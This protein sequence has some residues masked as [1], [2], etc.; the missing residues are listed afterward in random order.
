MEDILALPSEI[1]FSISQFLH[2]K[3]KRSY[4]LTCKAIHSSVF[5]YKCDKRVTIGDYHISYTQIEAIEKLEKCGD[6][7]IVLDAPPSIGKTLISLLFLQKKEG[8]HMIIV[9]PSLI[10]SWLNDIMKFFPSLYNE[11]EPEKSSILVY[12]SYHKIHRSYIESSDA[13][14]YDN[15]KI[16]LTSTTMHSR[17]FKFIRINIDW[18]IYDEAHMGDW[19]KGHKNYHK[20]LLL[21]ANKVLLTQY[22]RYIIQ[23]SSTIHEI[24]L[25]CSIVKDHVPL[26]REIYTEKKLDEV[27]NNMC[28]EHNHIIVFF[29]SMKNYSIPNINGNIFIHK[30]SNAEILD[31]FYNYNGKAVLLTTYK[32]LGTGHNLKGDVCVFSD[33]HTINAVTLL[34]TES[35]FLRVTNDVPRV[36]FI[37]L[38]D[39]EETIWKMR[40]LIALVRVEQEYDVK[41]IHY[42]RGWST[43]LKL[44]NEY[45][46]DMDKASPL[47][48]LYYANITRTNASKVIKFCKDKGL[49][50]DEL[51]K[52]IKKR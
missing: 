20:Q 10:D 48:I 14:H 46:I 8:I 7:F 24:S 39:H 17:I 11:K 19:W 31:K 51:R 23:L 44:H 21:S 38:C 28:K 34:Q 15:L 45:N 16:I 42:S 3:D 13:D 37:I 27:L 1:L 26:V 49:E 6:G 29:S 12:N 32:K 36:K 47:E 2:G 50:N 40:H 25:S 4:L 41:L 22:R 30:Q 52:M 9:P 35:R 18:E 33:A 43:L 5:F